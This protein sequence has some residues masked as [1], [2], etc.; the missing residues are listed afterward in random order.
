MME[1]SLRS[2]LVVMASDCPRRLLVVSERSPF[3]G[4]EVMSSVESECYDH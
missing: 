3:C 4:C 1:E 2:D